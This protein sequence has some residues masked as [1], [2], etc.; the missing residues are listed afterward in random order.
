MDGW[1]NM[2]MILQNY[3]EARLLALERLDV[4]NHKENRRV[5]NECN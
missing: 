3:N 5:R 1:M 4:E 2:T